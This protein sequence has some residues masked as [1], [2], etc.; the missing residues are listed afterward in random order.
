MKIEVDTSS[1]LDKSGDTV[2]SFSN[3][4]QKAI[5]IKQTV[6]NECLEKLTGKKLKKELRLFAACIYLLI[7]DCLDEIEE[8]VIDKEYPGHEEEIRWI[9]LNMLKGGLSHSEQRITIRF[10]KIGKKSSAHEVA[11]KTFRKERNPD[12]IITLREIFS[13]LLK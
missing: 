6:R 8:I 9:L 1:R 11:W 10:E 4:I 13:A 7:K 3:D 12:R 5:L 2:F